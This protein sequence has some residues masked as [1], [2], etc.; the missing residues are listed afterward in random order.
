MLP[1]RPIVWMKE[2]KKDTTLREKL[3]KG[4]SKDNG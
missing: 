1:E 3:Q 2:K 4:L